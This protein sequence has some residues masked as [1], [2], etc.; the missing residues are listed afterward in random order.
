MA[1]SHILNCSVK[2]L[3]FYLLKYKTGSNL[4]EFFSSKIQA[5]IKNRG[6]FQKIS[7]LF[8]AKP[9]TS[10]PQVLC[11]LYALTSYWKLTRRKRRKSLPSLPGGSKQGFDRE[12]VK[13]TLIWESQMPKRS[14]PTLQGR[15]RAAYEGQGFLLLLSEIHAADSFSHPMLCSIAGFLYLKSRKSQRLVTKTKQQRIK[16]DKSSIRKI[17][18][19]S[20]HSI[21]KC[22]IGVLIVPRISSNFTRN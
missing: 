16:N 22:Q 11:T 14:H 15:E 5:L 13:K 21:T 19:V 18:R 9:A 10:T 4:T 7:S 12:D 3:S 2:R 17:T 1:K 6:H 20:M 8:Q